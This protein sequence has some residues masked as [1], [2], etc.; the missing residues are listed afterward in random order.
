[1]QPNPLLVLK[2]SKPYDV[3][4]LLSP[5]QSLLAILKQDKEI[6]EWFST[7][8]DDL[9]NYQQE[10]LKTMTDFSEEIIRIKR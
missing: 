6:R 10:I 1:M 4:T 7:W 3:Q 8:M 9:V 5:K 2:A